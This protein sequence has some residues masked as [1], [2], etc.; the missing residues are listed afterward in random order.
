MI[1]SSLGPCKEDGTGGG[2]EEI[3]TSTDNFHVK[4]ECKNGKPVNADG[5]TCTDNNLVGC[6]EGEMVADGLCIRKSTSCIL[7]FTR[8]LYICAFTN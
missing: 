2:C 6:E 1:Y 7:Y 8:M 5:K 4:C 3:C